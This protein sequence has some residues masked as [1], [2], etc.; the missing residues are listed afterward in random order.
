MVSVAPSES[1]RETGTL[2]SDPSDACSVLHFEAME[3]PIDWRLRWLA[4]RGQSLSTN[5]PTCSDWTKR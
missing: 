4:H 3:D 1:V 2:T 5:L